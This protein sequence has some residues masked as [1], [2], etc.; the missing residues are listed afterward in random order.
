MT[1]VGPSACTLPTVEQP[2]RVAEFDAL[3]AG[4]VQ[5]VAPPGPRN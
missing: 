5:G 2:L 4:A 3:F 1:W